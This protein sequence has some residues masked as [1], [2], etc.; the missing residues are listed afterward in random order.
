MAARWR[1]VTFYAML[2]TADV[3]EL[4]DLVVDTDYAW[5]ASDDG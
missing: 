1:K 3:V 2:D 4:V 5:T